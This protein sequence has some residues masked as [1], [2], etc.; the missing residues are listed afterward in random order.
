MKCCNKKR[1]ILTLGSSSIAF[2]TIILLVIQSSVTTIKAYSDIIEIEAYEY[3]AIKFFTGDQTFAARLSIEP[4]EGYTP[5]RHYVFDSKNFRNWK[6]DRAYY[7]ID[8]TLE[9]GF[10]YLHLDENTKYFLVLDNTGV[11]FDTEISISI[12]PRYGFYDQEVYVKGEIPSNLL[13]SLFSILLIPITMLIVGLLRKRKKE[14]II[15]V[16]E[17]ATLKHPSKSPPGTTKFCT[18]CLFEI[19]TRV[20]ECPNCGSKM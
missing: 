4:V 17:Q 1:R 12:L 9:E 10:Y 14:T 6:N 8:W 7:S 15:V 5:V 2:I 13:Y 18:K 19:G 16:D 11:L 3:A 20:K